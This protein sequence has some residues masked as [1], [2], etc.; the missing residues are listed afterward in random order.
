[1]NDNDSQNKLAHNVF[2]G[3]VGLLD[4]RQV[5]YWVYTFPVSLWFGS[6]SLD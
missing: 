3:I 5:H 4:I 6:H 2:F 1:M